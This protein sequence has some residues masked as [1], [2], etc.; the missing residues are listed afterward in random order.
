MTILKNIFD[1]CYHFDFMK[2]CGTDGLVYAIKR[3]VLCFI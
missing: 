2:L 3:N 1:N